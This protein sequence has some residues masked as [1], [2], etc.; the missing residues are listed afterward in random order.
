MK[1][2]NWGNLKTN[3]CPVCGGKLNFNQK[4]QKSLCGHFLCD[5]E[6]TE[7]QRKNVLNNLDED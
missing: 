6:I 5:F 7:Q 4:E 1:P 2:K 3:R